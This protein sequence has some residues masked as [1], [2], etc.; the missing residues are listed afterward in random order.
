[1]VL[2]ASIIIP[3]YNE[4]KA[5]LSCLQQFIDLR[6]I[7]IIVVD[8]G[9]TD[10][11]LSIAQ[12]FSGVKVVESAVRGRA[13]QMNEGANHAT[14]PWLI[15]LHADTILPANWLEEITIA[16]SKLFK[17]GCF[18]IGREKDEK[19]PWFSALTNYRS[20][21]SRFPYGD[22]AIFMKK[23]IFEALGRYK[24][25]PIMEDYDLSRRFYRQYGKFYHSP[26]KVLT[27]YRRFQQQPIKS[28]FIMFWF[29]KLFRW[30]VSPN[31][32]AK[33]YKAIR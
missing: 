3:T 9:S 12:Q 33:F 22:Q 32:L 16:D 15:F 18:R 13:V 31:W 24:P 27:S 6:N 17:A 10:R 21:Y 26:T 2:S 20:Y 30:G 8:G 4:E 1:M 14:Q 25:I 19:I 5:I 28:A 23:K 11:T 7:E 29:P